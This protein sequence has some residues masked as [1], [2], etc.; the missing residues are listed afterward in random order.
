[1]TDIR[2]AREKLVKRIL[3]GEGKA[4]TSDRRA[5][6]D[7][8]SLAEPL[9]SLV[10]KI[11]THAWQMTDDDFATARASRAS[12]D[13]LFEMAV[14]AAVGQADRQ[15]QTALAALQAATATERS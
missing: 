14:C 12:E 2:Q 9:S 4:P 10:S 1:M 7:N 15:Y 8:Q 6:F 11:A 5:A 3:E 13:Q